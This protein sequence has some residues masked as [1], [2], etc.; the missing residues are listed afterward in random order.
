MGKYTDDN[1]YY[2]SYKKSNYRITVHRIYLGNSLQR[3]V[4]LIIL[5]LFFQEI[6]LLTIEIYTLLYF[7]FNFNHN[8]LI[9]VV[10]NK[11]YVCIRTIIGYDKINYCLSIHGCDCFSFQLENTV[12]VTIK[13]D[14]PWVNGSKLY[15]SFCLDF[16][17]ISIS[18]RPAPP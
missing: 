5:K 15:C 10:S 8:Q 18:P 7:D 17:I 1:N 11:I 16:L 14:T 9:Y 3:E 6:F 4:N 12:A 13:K 2:Q